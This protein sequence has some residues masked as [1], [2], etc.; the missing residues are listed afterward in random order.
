MGANGCAGRTN[1]EVVQCTSWDASN[2]TVRAVTRTNRLAPGAHSNNSTLYPCS[3]ST[4]CIPRLLL[5]CCLMLDLLDACCCLCPV[6]NGSARREGGTVAGICC[7]GLRVACA[8]ACELAKDST[9][10]KFSYF[11]RHSFQRCRPTGFR[12]FISFAEPGKLRRWLTCPTV[13]CRMSDCPT[14]GHAHMIPGVA[15][16]ILT[17]LFSGRYG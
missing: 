2:V 15:P 8:C 1:H 10:L 3:K 4:R 16:M 14:G 9:S 7:G 5:A 13:G 11:F 6:G 12:K 17:V